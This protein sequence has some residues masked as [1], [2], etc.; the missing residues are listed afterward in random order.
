MKIKSIS[1]LVLAVALLFPI[2]ALAFTLDDG[3][4]EPPK[5]I[6]DDYYAAGENVALN[7]EVNGDFVAAGGK[8]IVQAPVSKDVALVGGNVDVESEIGDG[9]RI[10]GGDV[11][12]NSIVKGDL[13]V[14]GGNILLGEKGFV[15]R[16]FVFGGGSAQINGTVNGNVLAAVNELT[17]NG[18]IQGNVKLLNVEKIHFGPQGKVLGNFSYRSEV[19]SPEIT[20]D[21]VKGKID[22]S[23]TEVPVEEKD[24]RATAWEILSGFSIF[25]FLGLLFTGLFFLWAFRYIMTR[26][27]HLSF[28]KSLPS[29]G[30]GLITLITAPILSLALLVTGIGLSLGLVLFTVWCLLL[31]FATLIASLII[32]MKFVEVDDRSSF[33]RLYGAFALGAFLYS[34]LALVPVL[35]WFL[36]FALSILAIGALVLFAHDLYHSEHKKKMI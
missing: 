20:P 32:G 10:A 33:G 21:T 16:D 28:E 35:G 34:A 36:R 3:K 2:A 29:L 14:G 6:N 30:I 27:A 9:A 8:I 23:S 4:S 1:P 17:I 24:M 7:S 25:G 18:P 5:L 15:G 13:L 31:Y 26:T 19:A 12:V 22:Y 11:T